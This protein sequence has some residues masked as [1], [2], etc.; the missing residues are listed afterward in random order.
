MAQVLLQ[1]QTDVLVEVAGDPSSPPQGV[2]SAVAQVITSQ[3]A[4]ESL[5]ATPVP[6]TVTIIAWHCQSLLC[7]Q[8]PSQSTRRL[9]SRP[10]VVQPD[11]ARY[12]AGVWSLAGFW[13]L[14]KLYCTCCTV[15]E[16]VLHALHH[17]LI[18]WLC[19]SSANIQIS[20]SCHACD[21]LLCYATHLY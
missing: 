4:C 15:Q 11:S 10:S 16:G 13:A 8:H 7:S 17:F 12:S 3:P 20:W 14:N 21:T 1:A 5:P 19:R 9:G 18:V 2:D 6:V